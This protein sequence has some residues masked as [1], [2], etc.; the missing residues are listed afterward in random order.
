MDPNEIDGIVQRLIAN[1]H[2]ED[3]L[4]Q[5]HRAGSSDP[6][7]YAALLERVG[8][9]TPDPSYA[10]HWLSEAANV[11]STTL[12]DAHHAAEVLLLAVVK[13][14][15]QDL[16]ADRLASLYREKGD[17]KGL[18]AL[19]EKRAK[20]LAPFASQDPSIR[21]KLAAML[22]EIGTLWAEQPLSQPI[23]ALEHFRRAYETDPNAVFAIYSARELLKA[24]QQY[25]EALP[26]FDMEQVLVADPE[27]KIAL[28]RDQADVARLAQDYIT[29]SN[30]LRNM[31]AYSPD[32]LA[33][34][35][36]QASAILEGVRMG[37]PISPQDAQ[38][39]AQL[40]VALAEMYP[41]EHEYA[42]S[43]SVLAL[44]LDASNDRAIQLATFFGEPLGKTPELVSW[45]ERYLTAN[46]A[47]AMAPEISAKYAEVQNQFDSAEQPADAQYPASAPDLSAPASLEQA[48]PEQFDQRHSQEAHPP[49]FSPGQDAPV[50]SS[51]AASDHVPSLSPERLAALLDEAAS[52]ASKHKN[53]D[54]LEAYMEVLRHDPI[55]PEALSWVDEH[56]RAKR[57]F[58]ELRDVYQAASRAPEL[59]ADER[60]KYLL[61]VANICEQQLRDVDG[62]IQALKQA[63]QI[64]PSARDNLRRLLEKGQRW[65]DLAVLI[66]QEIM[67]APDQEGQIVLLKQLASMHE[68]KRR[69]P[70][71][72]GETW[73][74]LAGMLI[75]DESPIQNA[76]KLLEQGE[77]FDLAAEVIA[78][79]VNGIER[80]DTRRG[81][82]MSLG[83]LRKKI[84]D[85]DGAADAFEHAGDLG[86]GANAWE[87][88]QQCYEA[89]QNWEQAA[90]VTQRRVEFALS[91][92]EQAALNE[93]AANYFFYAGI[94]HE[95]IELLTQAS[96]LT[97]DNDELAGTL[98]QRYMEAD[99]IHDM[100]QWML[101]RAEQLVDKDAR[102]A[103]RKRVATIQRDQ[104]SDIEGATET[105][106]LVIQ[107]AQDAEALRWLADEA[108]ERHDFDVEVSLLERLVGTQHEPEQKLETQLRLA[109][110]YADDLQDLDAAVQAY[111]AVINDIDDNNI[112][113]VH[114][115]TDLESRRGNAQGAVDALEKWLTLTQDPEQRAEIGR[116]L[117]DL[118]L[119]SLNDAQ[120]ATRSLEIV[121]EA[122]SDDLDA[123]SRLVELYEQ[124]E[125]WGQMATLLTVLVETEG[126]PEEAAQLALR[127][128]T[129]LNE[130][131]NRGQ[132]AL[133]VLE[134]LAN[135]GVRAC[136]DAYVEIG[137]QL[138]FK[139]IVAVKLRDW[140][141]LA[142]GE[143]KNEA[144]LG[145]F[146]RF[147]EMER[148]QDAV[149]VGIE[150]VRSQAA[151]DETID[152]LE[153]LAVRMRDLETLATVHDAKIR[154]L[155]GAERADELCRQAQM[156]VMAGL[157]TTE[158]LQH[159]EQALASV[160]PSSAEM[161]LERLAQ[162]AVEPDL[163]IDLYERQV[164]R[165]KD[166]VDRLLA[167][168]RA[169]QVA[170]QHDRIERA[171][172]M[173]DIA[174]GAG[175]K[176]EVLET[177]EHAARTGDEQTGTTQLRTAL[178]S[179]LASGVHGARDG[180]RTRSALLRRAA[181]IA[182]RELS[183]TDQAFLW[184]G[185]SLISHVEPE[186]LDA[187][188]ELGEEIGDLRR[189]EAVLNSALEQVFDG[190]FVRQ[191][192]QRRAEL[193][194]D[195]LDDLAGAAAD[196][197]RLHD[198][199]PQDKEISEELHGLLVKLRDWRGVVQL[200]EDQILR[201]KDPA[202]RVEL[203]RK[204]ARM[205]EER[206]ADPREAADAW[207][208]VLRMKQGDQ[209]AQEGLERAKSNMLKVPLSQLPPALG[210]AAEVP[211]I[212]PAP[213]LA[214]MGA[215][216]DPTAQTPNS[217]A[218]IDL[219]QLERSEGKPSDMPRDTDE[220]QTE[221]QPD[222]LDQPIEGGSIDGLVD[223]VTGGTD[224]ETEPLHIQPSDTDQ[225]LSPLQQLAQ[226][227]Q[228]VL[229][230]PRQLFDEPEDSAD[231]DEMIVDESL[232]VS[233]S[234]EPYDQI[235]QGLQSSA[236]STD[237]THPVEL[238][239]ST[240][241]TFLDGPPEQVDPYQGE[242]T[243]EHERSDADFG[244]HDAMGFLP[245]DNSEAAMNLESTN[246]GTAEDLEEVQDVGDDDLIMVADNEL[247][248]GDPSDQ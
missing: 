155:S 141:A 74:R 175:V 235:D 142:A 35:Q 57:K 192:L 136:R 83:E 238:E 244:S 95:G 200:L 55:S 33:L 127:Q 215:L 48:A 60:G 82:L 106:N 31:R 13:D 40:F 43:Y 102:V 220:F 114:A 163:I 120:R 128:A 116:R 131:L 92:K 201:G 66:D 179:R 27:R 236:E 205:W 148:D 4:N 118:Y 188:Q 196:L 157:P 77:R 137:D 98:E 242:Q 111:Q 135:E 11:W 73:G 164:S 9:E 189:V 81:L 103:L 32:D 228:S 161:L 202:H 221:F 214:D 219:Q 187:L 16:A 237:S 171:Q 156:L 225:S 218:D 199:S 143:E 19:L 53:R 169:A 144:F 153:Q 56:F 209:E 58:A 198:L 184:L 210:E 71:G 5:A 197:K 15:T 25:A 203:A 6:R 26:L 158:A 112:E 231:N 105:L 168:A 126:D 115:L 12:G 21:P 224:G 51:A 230:T 36:E 191:L 69:D 186:S 213:P 24:Q 65:D 2:D 167:L 154:S 206:L 117:A 172:Q 216:A 59:S 109:R 150:L 93:T 89:A 204:A 124:Q 138:G 248:P 223:G 46:P 67:D 145:A 234:G 62:A 20:L 14:P 211:P 123:V 47:G 226:Q 133:A 146:T 84:G 76:V 176:E 44:E 52:F 1:P 100:V 99:R 91:P 50:P 149:Q 23:R 245:M 94:G 79:N 28:Y 177:L 78:D 18:V 207:R 17:M 183:N 139:G 129:V 180:G 208:R 45:W 80:K 90:R 68:Q 194:R 174:L 239:N 70:V 190:P 85:M 49:S 125:N 170:G 152:Q 122:D 10:A 159:G 87:A 39:G 140:Y 166:P 88:A 195:R 3:A 165:C 233:P 246:D 247:L 61:K 130:Q 185:E 240:R 193:R 162:I 97:P 227:G 96:D 75:G 241:P 107:E 182:H 42:Y 212:P 108:R 86:A 181:A 151:S 132:D 229:E 29:L 54:A 101:R 63:T 38:E 7:S 64:D 119:D 232:L 121:H 8:H 147:L 134:N 217:T 22:E 243:D 72:A 34:V 113:A 160:P 41:E 178:A 222:Q 37:V 110:A 104:L 173:F 30:T